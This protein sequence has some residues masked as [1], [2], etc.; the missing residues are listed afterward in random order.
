VEFDTILAKSRICELGGPSGYVCW[1][2]EGVPKKA[3]FRTGSGL[4]IAAWGLVWHDGG[5]IINLRY[6]LPQWNWKR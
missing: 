5:G 2:R 1:R 4:M 6:T 3:V